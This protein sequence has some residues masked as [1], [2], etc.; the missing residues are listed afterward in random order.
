[1]EVSEELQE[2]SSKRAAIKLVLAGDPKMTVRECL[3]SDEL[4]Q[5]NE[6]DMILLCRQCSGINW[7]PVRGNKQGRMGMR[8][9]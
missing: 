2:L 1:M 4:Q 9:R 7:W 6:Q 8:W 3:V 5:G